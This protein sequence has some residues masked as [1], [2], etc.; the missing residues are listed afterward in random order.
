MLCIVIPGGTIEWHV[1]FTKNI[2][3]SYYDSLD[4]YNTRLFIYNIY[5]YMYYF[6]W[7]TQTFIILYLDNLYS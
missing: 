4:E 3:E 7:Y 1:T 5:I 2:H 6:L